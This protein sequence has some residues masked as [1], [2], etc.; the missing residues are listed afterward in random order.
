MLQPWLQGLSVL[1]MDY[2]MQVMLLDAGGNDFSN[3]TKPPSNWAADYRGFL[4]K[5]QCNLLPL[6]AQPYACGPL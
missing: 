3:G 1:G 4:Q 6:N 2:L 5:V